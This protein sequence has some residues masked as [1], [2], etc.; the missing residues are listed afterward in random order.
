M[1]STSP[2]LI[3]ISN[4]PTLDVTSTP[5]VQKTLEPTQTYTSEPSPTH[6]Y[7]PLPTPIAGAEQIAFA[8][9]R[10]GAV[11]IWLMNL[12]GSNLEMITN[13][14][15]GVCQPRWS[16]NGERIIFISPCKRNMIS[17]PGASLFIVNADGSGLIPL[18][19]VPGGDY[20][21][22]WSPD[23]KQVAFTSL[24][25][26]GVPGIFIMDLNDYTVKSLVEDETRAISQPAWSPDGKHIAY[27]NSDNR[28][29]IMDTNGENRYGLIKAG[30]DY[31]T[32]GPAWSPDGS[33][34][35]YIRSLFSD[36]T[37][38]TIL[39]AVPYTETGAIPV[40]VPNSQLVGDV[41]YSAD[42]YWLLFTSWFSGSHDIEV[43][44]AN[45][46]DRHAIEADPA[47]DFD[48]VWRP[49]FSNQP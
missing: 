7:T 36:I 37:G 43:M 33:V 17:Y 3:P 6:T 29:W 19:S 15:E 45:G 1:S 27:V 22:S 13:I 31:V 25:K 48:P 10:S 34:V 38:S 12:D 40:E 20:D 47:Y 30:G 16:P 5:T 4:T 46:V 9:N 14:P 28:I 26:N 39:M 35:I 2:P 8:S 44:R 49:F 23:G 42:R 18:P 32:N 24:R 11:E 21:P 41:S